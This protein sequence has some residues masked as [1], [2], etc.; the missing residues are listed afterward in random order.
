MNVCWVLSENIPSE[1]VDH[2]TLS[3]VAPVWGPLS[4]WREYQCDNTI[5]YDF[6]DA[7]KMLKRAFHAVTNFYIPKNYYVD[8]GR[9]VGVKLFEGEFKD[10]AISHKEDIIILNL[11]SSV[12]DI[13]LLIG[14]DLSPVDETLDA[15]EQRM[16][17]AYRHNV[18]TII[19]DNPNTQ[20]VLVNYEFDLAE[21]LKE[22]ENLTQDTVDEVIDLLI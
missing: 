18:K 17:K 9:P 7:H 19:E 20:F 21:N 22:L 5:C 11:V 6:D 3:T 12:H 15:A 8:L 2:T 13:V 1:F 10:S 14:F 4:T 16:L